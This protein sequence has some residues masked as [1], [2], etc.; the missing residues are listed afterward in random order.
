MNVEDLVNINIK[1]IDG[2]TIFFSKLAQQW[3]LIPYTDHKSGCPNYGKNK[4]CP[5]NAPFKEEVKEKYS[6]FYLV[7]ADFDFI[8]YKRM[9]K[10]K[11]IG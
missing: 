11:H 8:S 6:Y 1:Q 4:L 9:M 10:A 7:Y 2:D 5:P 3:C